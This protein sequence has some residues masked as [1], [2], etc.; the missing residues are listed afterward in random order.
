MKLQDFDLPSRSSRS[1]KPS[2]I[3]L[4][5]DHTPF[6]REALIKC[7]SLSREKLERILPDR[8]LEKYE[9]GEICGC[10]HKYIHEKDKTRKTIF[11]R[12]IAILLLNHTSIYKFF[13]QSV[14]PALS[15]DVLQ[16]FKFLK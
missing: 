2:P 11:Q 1:Y 15:H 12:S 9:S 3:K 4:S 5:P 16:L 7:F 13:R 6:V 10:I 8:L 14:C